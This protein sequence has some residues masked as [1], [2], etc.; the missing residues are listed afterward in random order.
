MLPEVASEIIEDTN[1][2]AIKIGGHEF[3][4]LPRF[5]LGRGNDVRLCGFPLSEEFVYLSPAVEIEPEKD[6]AFVAVGLN[7]AR[8]RG[9]S[10]A[11]PPRARVC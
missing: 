3:A 8:A 11:V 6:R 2:V 10:A 7:V 4:Q 1:E 9:W 5:V